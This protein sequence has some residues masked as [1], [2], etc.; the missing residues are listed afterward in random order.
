ML[1]KKKSMEVKEMESI[2]KQEAILEKEK[3]EFE[4][5]VLAEDRVIEE[6]EEEESDAAV[7]SVSSLRKKFEGGRT[8]KFD[9]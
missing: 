5:R 9:I 6:E 3:E 7:S 1:V 4:L 2:L 8:S